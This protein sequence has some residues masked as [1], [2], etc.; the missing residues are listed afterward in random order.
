MSKKKLEVIYSLDDMNF[1]DEHIKPV[2]DDTMTVIPQPPTTADK[3]KWYGNGAYL[4]YP[5]MWEEPFPNVILETMASG[6]PIIAFAK[7]SLPETV[8]DG[9]T[10]FLVNPSEDDI[11]GDFIVKKT[12]IDGLHEA[13]ERITSLSPAE[14]KEMRTHSRK[15]VETHFSLDKMIDNY[16]N[17]YKEIINK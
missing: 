2:V 3:N 10:G 16:V 11:R 5:I 13:I 14:Y 17:L 12:G 6:T 7:G 9:E 8:K 1:Y 4:L 15:R